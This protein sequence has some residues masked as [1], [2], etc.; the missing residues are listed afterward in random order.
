MKFCY[1]SFVFFATRS[2]SFVIPA[3]QYLRLTQHLAQT[4]HVD[5][6]RN[7]IAWALMG[8]FSKIGYQ[9]E[10]LNIPDSKHCLVFL[11]ELI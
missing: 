3:K 9:I 8:Q 7:G 4:Y 11:I 6:S 2:P 5:I 10:A 1:S